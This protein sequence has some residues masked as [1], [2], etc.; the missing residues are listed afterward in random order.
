MPPPSI[1]L[2]SSARTLLGSKWASIANDE[3]N[4]DS[5]QVSSEISE[6]IHRSI[7]SKT[8]TYRYVLPTQLLAKSV[9][10]SLDCRYIQKGSENPSAFDARSLC[11]S[12]IVE[13]DRENHGVL[14]A[15]SD[16]YVSKP[17]R[18]AAIR[19]D[20]AAHQRD[21]KGFAD[22]ITVLEFAE[23]NPGQVDALLDQVLRTIRNRLAEFAIDYPVPLRASLNSTHKAID[24]MLNTRSGGSVLQAIGAALFTVSGRRFGTHAKVVSRH[25]NSADEATGSAADIEC[26]DDDDKLVLAIEIKDRAVTLGHVLEKIAAIRSQAVREFLIVGLSVPIASEDKELRELSQREFAAG[27]NIYIMSV[28]ECVRSILI[29]LGEAGR[30]DVLSAIS[31]EMERQRVDIAHRRR[32]RDALRD[33]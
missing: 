29:L 17:L 16:P 31:E 4:S 15:S 20:Y 32:W 18:I 7:N 3:P 1:E 33:M 26:L 25:V 6:A 24:T 19:G 9:D 2:E 5:K 21:K 22:L 14:G 28:A 8:K 23:R 13:F 10:P 27:H 30:R 11:T 12:V